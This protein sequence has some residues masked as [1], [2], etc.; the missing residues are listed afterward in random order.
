MLPELDVAPPTSHHLAVLQHQ[1]PKIIGIRH[2]LPRVWF[3]NALVTA[4]AFDALDEQGQVLPGFRVEDVNFVE[5][6]LR[7]VGRG[8]DFVFLA[9]EH[10]HAQLQVYEFRRGGQ[11]ARLAAFRKDDS[12]GMFAKLLKNAL[13]KFHG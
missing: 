3:R 8:L 9:E 12:F 2:D 6:N 13:D 11:D 1:R 10:R 7:L 4:E 5:G